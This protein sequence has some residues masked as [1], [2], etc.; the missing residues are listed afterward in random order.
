MDRL[1]LYRIYYTMRDSMVVPFCIGLCFGLGQFMGKYWLSRKIG[2]LI[3][4]AVPA[5]WDVAMES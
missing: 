3:T 2:L 4:S 1:S 5:S